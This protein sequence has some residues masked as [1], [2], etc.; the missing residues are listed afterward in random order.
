MTLFKGSGVAIVTPFDDNLEIDFDRFEKLIEF[1]IENGTDALIVCGTTG[2][3]ATMTAEEQVS[4][5][6]FAVDKTN[7]WIPIIAGAGGNN[8]KV[9]VEMAKKMEEAGADGILSVNPYYNKGTQ[10]GIV[11]HYHRQADSVSIPIIIYNVPGR[12]GSNMGPKLVKRIFEHENITGIKEASGNI[13]Q[14]M[15]VLNECEDIDMYSGNDDV[16]IPLMS[17]GSKGVISVLA[18]VLPRETSEMCH[19]YLDGEYEKAGLMQRKYLRLINALFAEVNPSPVKAC[20]DL[21]GLEG[22]KLRLP[23]TQSSQKTIDE[24]KLALEELELI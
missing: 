1:Q 13:V 11:E 5:V 3:A 24:L 20:M 9:A 22:G 15:E 21:M 17:I 4:L 8:T 19:L 18:N 2:E 7:G 10:D 16:I 23:L 12:T 6:S 14:A